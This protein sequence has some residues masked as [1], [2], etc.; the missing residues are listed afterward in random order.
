VDFHR[1]FS[2]LKLDTA[3]G[4]DPN[5][6]TIW[7]GSAG[8]GSVSLQ[9]TAG[10]AYDTPPFQAAIA[11]YPW[12]QSMLNAS[13]QEVQYQAT[14]QAANCTTLRCLRNVPESKLWIVNQAMQ[15]ISY[16]EGAPGTGVGAFWTGPVV[17][18]KFVQMLPDQSFKQGNFYR[19]PL[20]MDRDIYEVCNFDSLLRIPA[21]L[22][23]ASTTA[24]NQSPR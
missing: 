24:T 12:W 14:L 13:Q 18:G 23:R 10:G 6:V 4:G 11:E 16:L 8:G 20:M 19:V 7:G 22:I 17:D 21:N 3:F 2:G 5:R 1:G 15:N 9:L